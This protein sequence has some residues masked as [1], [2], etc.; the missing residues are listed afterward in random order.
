MSRH[1]F[2]L[3]GL[4][5]LIFL[6]SAA[7]IANSNEIYY[8]VNCANCT[9]ATSGCQYY[10]STMAYYP[11]Q[12]KSENGEFPPSIVPASVVIVWE[13]NVVL[14]QFPT[15]NFMVTIDA[16]AKTKNTFDYAGNGTTATS[17]LSILI[18]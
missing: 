4:C 1:F 5:A 9:I 18:N 7:S 14:G 15:T 17:K 2:R 8:L 10:R 12:S 3:L 11:M 6:A 13:G 16:N